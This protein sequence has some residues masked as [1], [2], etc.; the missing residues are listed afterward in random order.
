MTVKRYVKNMAEKDQ[1]KKFKSIVL[2]LTDSNGR[3]LANELQ[4]NAVFKPNATFENVTT[5][6]KSLSSDL[7]N[8]NFLI[9]GY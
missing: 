8:E 5:E 7:T 9:S 6:A 4:V 3:G 2:L 1:N